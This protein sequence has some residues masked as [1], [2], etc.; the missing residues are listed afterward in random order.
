MGAPRTGTTLFMQWLSESGLWGYPNNAIS[1]FYA[2]PYL[3]A[4]IQQ[5]LIENDIGG[6][7]SDYKK[8]GPFTSVFG[9]T[10]GV[11]APNKFWYFRRCFFPL[12]PET[13]VV[14]PEALAHVNVE[15]LNRE[16]ASLEAALEKPLAMK[17]MLLNW[18]IPFLDGCLTAEI[19]CR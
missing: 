14:P 15:K 19:R 18:H 10:V 5:I 12:Y 2:A 11:L 13:D 7:I 3:G 9:K 1:R 17:G 6:E 16:L 8:T 4:R